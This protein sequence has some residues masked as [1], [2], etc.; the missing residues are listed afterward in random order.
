MNIKKICGYSH[1]RYSNGY[2]YEYGT[3]FGPTNR[4]WKCYYPYF[5]HSINI[6]TWPIS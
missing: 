6:P 5:I 3:N 4:I 1:N 2:W